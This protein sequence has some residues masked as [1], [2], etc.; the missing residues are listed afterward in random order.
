MKRIIP[1]LVLSL[2]LFSCNQTNHFKDDIIRDY[3]RMMRNDGDF[4]GD[5]KHGIE[6]YS[7]LLGADMA[8]VIAYAHPDVDNEIN[9]Y[10]DVCEAASYYQ[11]IR[12]VLIDLELFG[13]VDVYITD[14][15]YTGYNFNNPTGVTNYGAGGLQIDSTFSRKDEIEYSHFYD[16][17]MTFT[18]SMLAK[19]QEVTADLIHLSL[20]KMSN[21]VNLQMDGTK[22][23]S[24]I[25]LF[26]NY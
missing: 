16:Y 9:I 22:D 8:H 15:A 21:W 23:I 24:F 19:E 11:R 7:G 25:H 18:K 6:L 1:F 20:Q 10:A 4:N 14:K 17:E 2:S 3:V 5:R 26:E 13:L 12:I